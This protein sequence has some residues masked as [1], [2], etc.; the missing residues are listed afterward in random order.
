MWIL[1]GF[2]IQLSQNARVYAAFTAPFL[3]PQD[4]VVVP[5]VNKT[6]LFAHGSTPSAP[7]SSLIV[8]E[9][10][11]SALPKRRNISPP[12]RRKS[13]P[14]VWRPKTLWKRRWRKRKQPVQSCSF[15]Q[16]RSPSPRQFSA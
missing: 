9:A 6:P 16:E 11:P 14:A 5:P 15:S 13:L 3:Q 1:C 2:S 4:I 7:A 10:P 12:T 8:T